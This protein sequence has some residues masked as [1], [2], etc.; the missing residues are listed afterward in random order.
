MNDD[1]I[2]THLASAICSSS[3]AILDN[4]PDLVIQIPRGTILLPTFCDLHLHAPQFLYQGTGLDLPLMQWLDTYTLKS[5][6]R[7]DENSSLA[8]KVYARLATHLKEYGTGAVLLFG[9]L[10]GE[11]KLVS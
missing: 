10:K 8:R 6:A 3:A 9:T 11:T 7:V 4:S 2:I 5:E 1:G